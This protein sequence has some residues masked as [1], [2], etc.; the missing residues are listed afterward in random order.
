MTITFMLML[1]KSY[2]ML[3][4]YRICLCL[5]LVFFL[6]F[7]NAV[8]QDEIHYIYN[9]STRS[10]GFIDKSADDSE[11]ES[12]DI[13]VIDSHFHDI[14]TL[15]RDVQYVDSNAVKIVENQF[16]FISH[17]CLIVYN[18]ETTI[19]DTIYR[20][21]DGLD[22]NSFCLLPSNLAIVA[23]VNYKTEDITFS[24]LDVAFNKV[25]WDC[26]I[27]EINVGL[28][29]LRIIMKE[30]GPDIVDVF[31]NQNNYHILMREKTCIRKK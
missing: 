9:D 26:G 17:E 23:S 16:Y 31:T 11:I 14:A 19:Y 21:I 20:N 27:N 1:K 4:H 29:Y 3:I 8:A 18:I 22:I 6:P 28:E 7:V 24:V 30:A 25:L 2:N 10:I 5:I 13:V 12:Y 15:C